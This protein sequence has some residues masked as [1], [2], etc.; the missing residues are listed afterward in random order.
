MSD[1][2]T[3]IAGRVTVTVTGGV[4]DV[5]LNRPDKR[6]ALDPAMFEALAA[7]GERD[8]ALQHGSSGRRAPRFPP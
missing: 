3:D 6:N 8:S 1:M 2:T 7:A 4:A 5:R